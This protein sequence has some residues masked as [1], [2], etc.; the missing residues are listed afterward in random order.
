MTTLS[1]EEYDRS[2]KQ[3]IEESQTTT[4][5]VARMLRHR[6]WIVHNP[7][8][9]RT[10]TGEV[11]RIGDKGDLFIHRHEEDPLIRVETK[12]LGHE[13]PDRL[14]RWPWKRRGKPKVMVTNT[15]NMDKK[16]A[17]WRAG[18]ALFPSWFISLSSHPNFWDKSVLMI[19]VRQENVTDDNKMSG[20]LV[21]NC[22]NPLEQQ[23]RLCY[24]SNGDDCRVRSMREMMTYEP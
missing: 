9:I 3:R 23:H 18:K 17:Q 12:C 4:D 11:A 10:A 6:G 24:F 19:E 5:M 21:E 1:Q 13:F 15:E 22:W 7:G 2:T 20:W 16:L 14:S 8:I